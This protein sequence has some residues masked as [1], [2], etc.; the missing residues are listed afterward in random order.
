MVL[1]QNDIQAIHRSLDSSI[2][3]LNGTFYIPCELK[4]KLSDI[5]LDVHH[6]SL[7]ISSNDYILFPHETFTDLCLSGLSS[8][9]RADQWILGDIFLKNYYTV[10]TN[11]SSF[12]SINHLL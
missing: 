10:I 7:S 2:T 3:F 11:H 9:G 8:H 4:G 5:I 1:P 12:L 6:H